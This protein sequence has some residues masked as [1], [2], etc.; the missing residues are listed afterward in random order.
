MPVCYY[1]RENTQGFIPNSA[2]RQVLINRDDRTDREEA[3]DDRAG[4]A[5][6]DAALGRARPALRGGLRA[7]RLDQPD[8]ALCAVRHLAVEPG[9]RTELRAGAAVRPAHA[10]LTV[11]RRTA[12]GPGASAAA[13]ALA[14]G[15]RLRAAD[16]RRLRGF[17]ARA[18]ARAPALRSRAVVDARPRLADG[19][20]S[21][22]RGGRRLRLCRPRDRS[23]P[24]A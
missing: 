11:H 13:A 22:E 5:H 6:P 8:P 17:A 15:T 10:A 21:G 20:R 19:R 12:V 2:G 14:G 24:A 9:N 16:R 3:I 4:P 23:R 7:A 18:D 1:L